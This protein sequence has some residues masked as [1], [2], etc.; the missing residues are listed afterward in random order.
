MWSD[1]E[2]EYLHFSGPSYNDMVVLAHI[3][4]VFTEAVSKNHLDVHSTC[5]GRPWRSCLGSLPLVSKIYGQV[6]T[7]CHPR[8]GPRVHLSTSRREP[9]RRGTSAASRSPLS[10]TLCNFLL[11]A[12]YLQTNMSWRS[13]YLTYGSCWKVLETVIR[14]ELTL[15][16]WLSGHRYARWADVEGEHRG[17]R[18]LTSSML[19]VLQ[20]M[21]Q[22]SDKKY[23][24][25]SDKRNFLSYV[26]RKDDLFTVHRLVSL[27]ILHQM[28]QVSKS[29]IDS[30][31]NKI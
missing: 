24:A 14:D 23:L 13:T 27:H 31:F 19:S 29:I 4:T 18:Y 2:T 6:A 9:T 16:C 17:T 26:L 25:G 28:L 10:R 3:R 22:R 30:Q 11:A 21:L 15:W 8:S 20:C 12:R 7:R 5:Q 1:P